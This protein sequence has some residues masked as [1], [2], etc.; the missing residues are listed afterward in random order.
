MV[1][2][3][4]AKNLSHGQTLYIIGAFDSDGSPS[5]CRVSGAPKTWKRDAGRVQVP[6]KRGLRENGYLTE[7][8]LNDFTL[9]RP[10]AITKAESKALKSKQSREMRSVVRY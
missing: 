4:Q 5:R 7:N 2:L 1:T 3:S 9:E 10:N 6:I 8:N